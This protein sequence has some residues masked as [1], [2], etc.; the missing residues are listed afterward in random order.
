[1]TKWNRDTI[2][3]LKNNYLCLLLLITKDKDNS[4]FYNVKGGRKT[5]ILQFNIVRGDS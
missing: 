1:M 3:I 2:K 5:K 4:R